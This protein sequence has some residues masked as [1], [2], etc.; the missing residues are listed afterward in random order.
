MFSKFL[1][2]CQKLC[3]D[4]SSEYSSKEAGF[5]YIEVVISMVIMTVGILGAM[6]ALTFGVV[7]MQEAE[8]RTQAKEIANSTIETIFA[9]RDFQTTASG[10]TI[11]S[12]DSIQNTTTSTNGIFLSDWNPVR[13]SSG[14]DGIYGTAD[15]ACAADA[16]CS[17]SPVIDG[18]ERKIDITDMVENNSPVIRKRRLDVT[19]RF[20]VNNS[21]YR[22]E[23]VSTI[24]ANLPF[25]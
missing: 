21:N 12:W 6:S 17:A 11:N 13:Q 22:T 10:L 8:K 4:N 5:T 3:G 9:V 16:N 1:S 24:I 18:F 15:A 25:N 7:Y 23:Q 19:I 2:R 20:R 14:A